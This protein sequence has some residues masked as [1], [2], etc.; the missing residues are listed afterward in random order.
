MKRKPECFAKLVIGLACL[1]GV[2]GLNHGGLASA[3]RGGFLCDTV[4]DPSLCG[5]VSPLIPMQSTE[6]VHMGLVWK[7]KSPTPK[8]LFHARFPEYVPNDIADPELVDLVIAQGA[9]TTAGNQFNTSLRVV[10]NGFDPF[11]GGVPHSSGDDSFQRLTYGGFLM[12]Q[13]LSQSVPTRIVAN[14]T[15]ERSLLFDI[16]HPDAFRNNG[17]F[18]T[19]LLDEADF[20]LN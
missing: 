11:L 17:K 6:A 13:G 16:A 15:M 18:H 20:A 3:Q 5:E 9:L 12:R 4:P 10:L 7:K 19:A 14:R 8:I 2:F 1:F